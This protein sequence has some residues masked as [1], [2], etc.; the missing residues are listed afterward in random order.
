MRQKMSKSSVRV[1]N[2]EISRFDP[3]YPCA[4]VRLAEKRCDSVWCR[5]KQIWK[6]PDLMCFSQKHRETARASHQMNMHWRLMQK[7]CDGTNACSVA[8]SVLPAPEASGSSCLRFL[9]GL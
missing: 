9:E 1:A 6:F 3:E 7:K 5:V 2:L 8:H 4:E